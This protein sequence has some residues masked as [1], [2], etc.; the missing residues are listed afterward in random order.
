MSL[1][2]PASPASPAAAHNIYTWHPQG[3]RKVIFKKQTDT[4]SL[5]HS[6]TLCS[7]TPIRYSSLLWQGEGWDES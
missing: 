3:P 7:H 1:H 6:L 2:I 5:T 4:H